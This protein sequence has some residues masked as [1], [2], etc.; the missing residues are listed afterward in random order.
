MNPADQQ[1]YE[2]TLTFTLISPQTTLDI[3]YVTN[4]PSKDKGSAIGPI[5]VSV[6]NTGQHE[7]LALG[8]AFHVQSLTAGLTGVP[9]TNAAG[10]LRL[11]DYLFFPY[12][13]IPPGY[14]KQFS[15]AIAYA[16]YS[17]GALNVGTWKVEQVIAC[18]GNSDPVEETSYPTVK[19]F[20]VQARTS[21][22]ATHPVFIYYLWNG[23]GPEPW[24]ENPKNYFVQGHGV[25]NAG[26]H[27][28]HGH[29]SDVHYNMLL[30]YDDNRWEIPSAM[31]T[32][33]ALRDAG[34]AK[35]GTRLNLIGGTWMDTA[36]GAHCRNCGFDLLLLVAYRRADHM[37]WAM[38]P[39]NWA[40]VNA[41]GPSAYKINWKQNIDGVAQHELGHNF[42]CVHDS[43]NCIMNLNRLFEVVL[44]VINPGATRAWCAACRTTIYNQWERF[45]SATAYVS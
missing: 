15:C 19:Q 2:Q 27:M 24:P 18:A 34:K 17:N 32:C 3:T 22:S 36:N 9:Y 6:R 35:V 13:S 21:G 12:D 8:I 30:C 20:T 45:Y 37:G 25:I 14:T 29:Y 28:F 10:A 5:T 7:A 38:R 23:Q 16:G 41:G 31:E 11:T 26:L 39:G 4:P 42:D 1:A 40:L 44:G 43:S 33:T